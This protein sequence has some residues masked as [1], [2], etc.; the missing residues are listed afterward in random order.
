MSEFGT[1]CGTFR[2][3]SGSKLLFSTPPILCM[4]VAITH[5]LR[6]SVTELNECD[7]VYPEVCFTGDFLTI[8]KNLCNHTQRKV[9]SVHEFHTAIFKILT[10]FSIRYINS[11]DYKFKIRL[12]NR[13]PDAI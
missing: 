8:S 1:N 6:K 4:I 11:E 5:F 3:L 2:P 10:Q 7:Y 13:P 9:Y 12:N